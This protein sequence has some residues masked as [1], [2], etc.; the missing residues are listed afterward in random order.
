MQTMFAFIAGPSTCAAATPFAFLQEHFF[1]FYFLALAWV[2]SLAI[3]S[4]FFRRRKRKPIF[5]PKFPN[6]ALQ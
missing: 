4:V 2:V 1:A 6:A 3:V 5:R